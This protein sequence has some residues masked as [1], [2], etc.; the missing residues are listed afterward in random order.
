M[1]FYHLSKNGA[2][3]WTCKHHT[4]FRD[5]YILYSKCLHKYIF[6]NLG[7]WKLSN[8]K[9]IGRRMKRILLKAIN[10]IIN[11]IYCNLV[12]HHHFLRDVK[13]I[14]YLKCGLWKLLL[15][16]NNKPQVQERR[17][18]LLKIHFTIQLGYFTGV[19]KEE[20]G[21]QSLF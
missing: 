9:W 3:F 11:H 6:K 13:F 15:K 10:W 19:K 5:Y 16:A 20:G 14:K 7:N 2:L 18:P 1:W 12:Y 8:K 17:P 21:C 4:A